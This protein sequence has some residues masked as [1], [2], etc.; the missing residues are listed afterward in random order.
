MQKYVVGKN[1]KHI[2]VSEQVHSAIKMYAK[3]NNLTMIEATYNLLRI[4][5]ASVYNLNSNDRSS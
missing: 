5:F 2:I 3:E 4:A 1:Q